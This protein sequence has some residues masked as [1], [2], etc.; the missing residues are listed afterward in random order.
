VPSFWPR[1]L[2]RLS[3]ASDFQ[4]ADAP[5]WPNI[6]DTILVEAAEAFPGKPIVVVENGCVV[7]AS[8]VGRPFYLTEHINQVRKARRRG[9]PVDTYICWSITSNREWGLRF[10]DSSDFGLY[11]IALDDDPQLTRVP[12]DS[13]RTYASL[14]TS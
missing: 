3:A 4:Y 13:C 1:D 10:D 9:A 2:H 12:T 6:L 14:I 11:H 5:V 8:G 7:R